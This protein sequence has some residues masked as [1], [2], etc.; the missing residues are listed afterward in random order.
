VLA[1]VAVK[2]D[3][4][5]R[6]LAHWWLNKDETAGVGGWGGCWLDVAVGEL[7]SGRRNATKKRVGW[8]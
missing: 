7:E 4:G 2:E 3:V 5:L 8:A 6:L 1:P